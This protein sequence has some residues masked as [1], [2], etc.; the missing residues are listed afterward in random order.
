MPNNT[1]T[2]ARIET[3]RSKIHELQIKRK[4][5][6]SEPCTHSEAHARIDAHVDVIARGASPGDDRVSNP[7][8]I[9]IA[10]IKPPTFRP[11]IYAI[12]EFDSVEQALAVIIP[13]EL[14]TFLH[15]RLDE[16]LVDQ[17]EGIAHDE[18]KKTLARLDRE[19]RKLEV[20]EELAICEFENSGLSL[21]RRADASPEI[22]LEVSFED[23]EP[24]EAA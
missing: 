10:R 9:D 14:K 4:S 13:G 16:H 11:G 20:E 23:D 19:I 15:A 21:H 22:V 5:V 18:R 6:A 12:C 8:Q 24:R 3:V 7:P 1:D 17:P 2:I